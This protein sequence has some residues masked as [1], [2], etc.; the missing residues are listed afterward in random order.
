MS[1]IGGSG[2]KQE[3]AMGAKRDACE[4]GESRE[5]VIQSTVSGLN[6]MS[7]PVEGTVEKRGKGHGVNLGCP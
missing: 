1:R 3:A 2:T 7:T 6:G 4:P 5:L